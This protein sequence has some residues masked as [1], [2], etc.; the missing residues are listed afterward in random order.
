LSGQKPLPETKPAPRAGGYD[1]A[2]LGD[3][4]R[5]RGQ[6][7]TALY[8]PVGAR[9][10]VPSV[11]HWK[12][13]HYAALLGEE[14]RP[15][16]RYYHVRDGALGRD[17]WVSEAALDDE[18]S[19]YFLTE[20]SSLSADWRL[21]SREEARGVVGAGVTSDFGGAG[22][23]GP[24]GSCP[25]GGDA[26]GGVGGSGYNQREQNQPAS[27]SYGNVGPHWSYGGAAHVIDTPASPAA[28][29]KLY[30]SSGGARTLKSFNTASQSFAPDEA[31]QSVLARVFTD[32]IVYERRLA[33][34]GKEIYRA[35]LPQ[36]TIR[37]VFLSQAV[38]PAG[39]ALSYHYDDAD[40]QPRA[41]R[42]GLDECLARPSPLGFGHGGARRRPR[43]PVRQDGRARRRGGRGGAGDRRSCPL[44]RPGAGIEAAFRVAGRGAQA[45][46]V[47]AR[48]AM[49]GG[50]NARRPCA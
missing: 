38:D 49:G 35:A 45:G 3:L 41:D 32:P 37:R 43:V 8:R 50:W 6:D 28:N 33:D 42:L 29:V 5:S 39:N 48:K 4:A 20:V 23:G 19:G 40:G 17:A 2:E 18:A 30:L 9:V 46:V 1:L 7:L 12:S 26:P 47:S 24:E 31:D 21:A 34:G 14:T 15:A 27:F 44:R 11:V 22:A 36:G 16:G 13:G 25:A 10:P